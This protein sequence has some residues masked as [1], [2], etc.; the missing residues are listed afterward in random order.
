MPNTNI[1]R[2]SPREEWEA[3]GLR[4]L[5]LEAPVYP[6]PEKKVKIL[7]NVGQETIRKQHRDILYEV[8]TP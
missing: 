6:V 4:H 2:P 5:L 1:N 3:L 7:K 8:C